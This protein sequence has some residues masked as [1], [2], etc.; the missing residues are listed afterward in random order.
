[1]ANA[2]VTSVVAASADTTI[3]AANRHRA[4]ATVYNDSTANCYLKFGTG[5]SSTS[6][7]VKLM[8]GAYY[9]IPEGGYAGAL[10]GYW[11][12]VNGSARVTELTK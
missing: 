1:M 6:F 3:L 10:N 5:A 9:E 4:G 12:A 2:A 7:T 8:P 11:D